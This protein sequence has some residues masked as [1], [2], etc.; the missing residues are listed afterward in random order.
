[1]VNVPIAYKTKENSS[2]H[3]TKNFN[4]WHLIFSYTHFHVL[5]SS[6]TCLL[7]VWGL[8]IF[9][10]SA[11]TLLHDSAYRIQFATLLRVSKLH[12]EIKLPLGE[13]NLSYLY[14]KNSP[15]LILWNSDP[16]L[17]KQIQ[18]SS[19]YCCRHCVEFWWKTGGKYSL[20]PSKKSHTNKKYE[21]IYNELQYKAKRDMFIE[22]FIEGHGNSRNQWNFSGE[23]MPS[24]KWYFLIPQFAA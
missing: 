16:I 1:M 21:N 9:V 8:V 18:I 17:I 20:F 11:M 19:T 12:E 15:S 24:N 14:L 10:H 3:P 13:C 2:A 22:Q 6:I 23:N 5:C 4:I 7:G